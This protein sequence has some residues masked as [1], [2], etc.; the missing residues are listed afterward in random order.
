MLIPT[1]CPD[2]D[3]EPVTKARAIRLL[4]QMEELY[5]R[6]V[7]Q[8]QGN[9]DTSDARNMLHH[10]TGCQQALHWARDLVKRISE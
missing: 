5:A 4:G 6:I 7:F 9:Q 3:G 2:D 1:F 10:A 8:T